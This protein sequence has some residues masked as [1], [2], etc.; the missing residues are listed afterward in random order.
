M[1]LDYAGEKFGTAL[2]ILASS[3]GR[4]LDRLRSAYLDSLM[5]VEQ[6]DIPDAL[7]MS[8]NTLMT[9]LAWITDDSKTPPSEDEAMLLVRRIEDL[10]G[11]LDDQIDAQYQEG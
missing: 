11:E 4:I 3:P 5:R 2:S 9:D 6:K 10:S 1:S 8:Y 7:L